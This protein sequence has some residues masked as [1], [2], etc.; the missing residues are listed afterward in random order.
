MRD[1]LAGFGT[2]TAAANELLA[3][4][5]ALGPESA[6]S[7]REF[8]AGPGAGMPNARDVLAQDPGYQF[9]I[10]EAAKALQG[11]AAA[12]GGALGGGAL[13]ALNQRVQDVASSEYGAAYDRFRQGQTDRFNRLSSL[14]GVGMNAAGQTGANLL[15]LG[16]AGIGAAQYTGNLGFQGAEAAGGA[17]QSGVNL[18]AQ[19]AFNTQQSLADLMTQAAN[20]RA[21]GTIGGANAWGNTLGG[22]ANTAMQ[23]GNWYQDKELLDQYQ[24]GRYQNPALQ[25][26][27]PYNVWRNRDYLRGTLYPK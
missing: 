23:V 17:R 15:G 25:P 22:I 4:Y 14:L 26:A 10:N 24:Q 27:T 11:S 5:L 1:A 19:N 21:A 9:R 3:P 16:Q 8:M 12:R 13:R 18:M 7:L 20:A 2:Q 6:T